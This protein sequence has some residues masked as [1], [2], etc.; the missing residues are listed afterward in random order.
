M[1]PENP[2]CA[3]SCS[4]FFHIFALCKKT[5]SVLHLYR[6]TLECLSSHPLPG[7]IDSTVNNLAPREWC[8][9]PDSFFSVEGAS[10]LLSWM[11]F[12]YFFPREVTYSDHCLWGD[13]WGMQSSVSYSSLPLGSSFVHIDYALSPASARGWINLCSFR[14]TITKHCGILSSNYPIYPFTFFP[15]I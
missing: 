8:P 9:S 10:L 2:F 6:R 5:P 14:H 3:N 7:T 4:L 13:K 12:T 1:R 15:D 11:F